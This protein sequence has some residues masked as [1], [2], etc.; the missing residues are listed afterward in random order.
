MIAGGSWSWNSTLPLRSPW[1]SW[2]GAD[3]G[4]RAD[5]REVAGGV[6]APG[7]AVADGP[8]AGPVV[9]ESGPGDCA[10]GSVEALPDGDDLCPTALFVPPG[11]VLA[12][13]PAIDAERTAG[14]G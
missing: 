10:Q 6:L 11:D 5:L 12:G 2:L 9:Q 1:M 14:S 13:A 3:T 8:G 7:D 4:R